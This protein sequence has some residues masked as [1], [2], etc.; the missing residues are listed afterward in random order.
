MVPPAV[1]VRASYGASEPLAFAGVELQSPGSPASS[2]TKART[3]ARGYFSF[4]PDRAGEWKVTVDD[5]MGHRTERAIQVPADFESSTPAP[6]TEVHRTE[7][8][9][10][11]VAILLGLTGVLYGWRARRAAQPSA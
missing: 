2:A 10:T 3:D 6:A 9:I 11:G 1:V 8:A 5:D 4:V 7:R